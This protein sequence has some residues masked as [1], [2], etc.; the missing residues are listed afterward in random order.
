MPQL[1]YLKDDRGC[2]LLALSLAV[3]R[4]ESV[5]QNLLFLGIEELVAFRL[6]EVDDDEPGRDRERASNTTLD[7]EDPAL[8]VSLGIVGNLREAV[9]DDVGK[10]QDKG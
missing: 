4:H 1:H 10:G 7:D 6:G 8:T 3:L 2:H 9:G 5:D